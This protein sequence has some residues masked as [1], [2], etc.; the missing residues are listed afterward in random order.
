MMLNC[1]FHRN[2]DAIFILPF[3]AV[4][5]EKVCL[6]WAEIT[7]QHL[8][9]SRFGVFSHLLMNSVSVTEDS[10]SKSVFVC[11]RFSSGR[12]CSK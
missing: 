1:L 8:S 3:V 7:F 2:L 5:Q 6:L 12:I 11:L 4:V 9:L 10:F